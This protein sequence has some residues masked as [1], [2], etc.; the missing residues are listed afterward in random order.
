M[1]Y[2]VIWSLP[3]EHQFTQLWLA[4]RLRF[5]ITRAADLIDVALTRD[6]NDCG[7]SREGTGRVMHVWPLGVSFEVDDAQHEVRVF[8]VW[9]I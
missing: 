2:A 5:A 4:S 9:Q 3:A 8:S 6:P 7:E 1:S